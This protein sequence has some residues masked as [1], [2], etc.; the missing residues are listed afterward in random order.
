MSQQPGRYQR[1]TSG[2]V[3]AMIVTLL[4]VGGFVGFR[5]LN[6]NDASRPVPT[7]PA[8]QVAQVAKA[9]RADGLIAPLPV[10]LPQGWRITSLSYRPGVA[11]TWHVGMLTA[12]QQYVGIEERRESVGDMVTKY[13]DKR[14]TKGSTRA[15][16]GR[17]WQTWTDDGGD[18][19]LTS[20]IG[21]FTYLVG[22][23][24]ARKDVETLLAALNLNP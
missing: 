19:A 7:V 17:Q 14:A 12:D 11:P 3:G 8:S 15:L 24:A 6:R 16:E 20:R 9:A 18:Y 1:T 5:A 2:L 21:Q 13:V 4:A 22:G 10:P 23:S